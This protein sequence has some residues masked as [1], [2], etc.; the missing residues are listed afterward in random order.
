MAIDEREEEKESKSLFT[1]DIKDL[2]GLSEP[3]KRVIDCLDKG[4]SSLMHPYVFKRDER[5]KM[6]I[7][8]ERSSQNAIIAFKEAMAQDMINVARTS[9]DR[10]ELH[11]IAEIYG[12]AMAEFQGIDPSK[13]PATLP[14]DEWSAHFYDCAKDCSD[15][16]IRV[17][18]SK[19][20][21]GEIKSPGKYFKRTL[22]YLKQLEKHEAEWFVNL[23]KYTLEDAYIPYFVLQDEILPMNQYQSLVDCGFLNSSD[24]QVVF[25]KDV[26]LKMKG[27]SLNLEVG[28]NPYHMKVMTFTDTGMQICGLV[29]VETDMTFAQ[30]L[31]DKINSSKLAKA[32]LL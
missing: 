14:S 23:C 30:S 15:D 28:D 17:I 13:L 29:N 24:C 8:Q 32:T 11:N 10:N 3:L 27:C 4:I 6:V 21:A 18:W 1:M 12:G 5:A 7:E 9:R 2:A 26:V 25:D 19:I 22:T 20:L 31:V 16:E